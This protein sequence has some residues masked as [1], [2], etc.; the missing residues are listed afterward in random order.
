MNEAETLTAA[1]KVSPLDVSPL[2]AIRLV[3]FKSFVDPTLLSLPNALTAI[4]GPNGCGKS[5]IID[6]VRWVMGE[7][8]AKYL[9]GESMSDVIFN[10]AH[11]R[12]PISQASVELIFDNSSGR[13]G[14]ELSQYNELSIK[15]IVTREN[16]SYYAL[17]GTR[18][19][20]K[21]IMDIFLGTGLGPRS[22]A[23][24][25]QGTVSRLIE[26]K[27]EELRT[28]LEE[29]AGISKYKERRKETEQRMLRTKENLERL[30]DLEQE[31]SKQVKKLKHQASVAEKYKT[32]KQQERHQQAEL[33]SMKW[34]EANLKATELSSHI[35]ED[36]TIHEQLKAELTKSIVQLEKKTVIQDDLQQQADQQQDKLYQ[37]HQTQTEVE[38]KRQQLIQEQAH[39]KKMIAHNEQ[40]ITQYQEQLE[41]KTNEL[42]TQSAQLAQLTPEVEELTQVSEKHQEALKEQENQFE[43][44]RQQWETVNQHS[45][46]AQQT[47]SSQQTRIKELESSLQR[48]HTRQQSLQKEAQALDLAPLKHKIQ[49]A[50]EEQNRLSKI[51]DELTQQRHHKQAEI[52]SQKQQHSQINHQ[53]DQLKRQLHSC[54]G[55][56]SSLDTLQEAALGKDKD[57]NLKKRRQWLETC[58]MA[59]APKLVEQL[60]VDAKW[61]PAVEAAFANMME[62]I[63][64]SDLDSFTDISQVYLQQNTDDTKTTT[65]SNLI[66]FYPNPTTSA[67]ATEAA[68]ETF[69]GHLPLSHYLSPAPQPFDHIF[70]IENYELAQ[71]LRP[72]LKSHQS[73]LLLDGTLMELDRLIIAKEYNEETSLLARQAELKKLNA[74][75][76]SLQ[77]N[78]EQQT[79]LFQSSQE[80]GALIEQSLQAI[81]EQSQ[82]EQRELANINLQLN[83]YQVKLDQFTIRKKRTEEESVDNEALI[84]TYTED[85]KTARQQLQAALEDMATDEIERNKL[86]TAETDIKKRLHQSK[87]KAKGVMQTLHQLQIKEQRLVV[88][89]RTSTEKVSELTEQIKTLQHRQDASARQLSAL[90]DP[91][92]SCDEKLA[93]LVENHLK[94]EQTLLGIRAEVSD[95]HDET[96]A[97]NQTRNT[98][99]QKLE[100]LQTTLQKRYLEKRELELNRQHLQT[101]LTELPFEFEKGPATIEETIAILLETLPDHATPDLWLQNI[102]NVKE[103]IQKLGAINLAAVDEYQAAHTREAHLATQRQDLEEALTTLESAIRKIDNETKERF[104][105][106]YEIVNNGF[107]TLFPKIFGGGSAHLALTGDNLLE[108][109]IA[110]MA[111]P[112]GKRNSTIHLLSGGEK[113]LTAIALVFAIFELNPAPFCM[114]D[115]VDAPLD[116]NNVHRFCRLVES[117]AE[118]IQFIYIS[119][120]K[121]AMEMAHQLAGVTMAEPGVSRLVSVDLEEASTLNTV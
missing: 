19:R 55:R 65:I 78:L 96:R 34:Q 61:Q 8:S 9:R 11:G 25:G 64:V 7:S 86:K 57:K 30:S 62:T 4:V 108:T 85:L 107:Q 33:L 47:V 89:H 49:T 69:E 90:I 58:G 20:R 52:S 15:R 2:K 36:E 81:T 113:A 22:Y 16:Q 27:P 41:Q 17:N 56:K 75:I 42:T 31:L 68:L 45:Y 48:L 50:T 79:H 119:H 100:T 87:E 18:C 73:I 112:P 83:G 39:L 98:L 114:L 91:I 71:T 12:K 40:E 76:E 74:E 116:D 43:T 32:L 14:G 67:A 23:I 51:C 117:M 110:V 118:R 70:P 84:V 37:H 95:A 80:S 60:T 88:E 102:N 54:S 109:G 28:F 13:F 29:A 120:N 101:Q 26:A 115:E 5:N 103:R 99:E 111:R 24:I 59:N 82:Q 93:E 66:L 46:A 94:L 63:L 97:L 1:P 121:M 72:K 105:S 92:A 106:T 21:D 44:W 10:G 6:A 38:Q 77:E 104:K 53:L 3:G 35:T